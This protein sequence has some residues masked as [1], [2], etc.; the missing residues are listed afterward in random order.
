MRN[1]QIINRQWCSHF[2]L[3]SKKILQGQDSS[4]PSV[5]SPQSAGQLMQEKDIPYI[6]QYLLSLN[7]LSTHQPDS[8]KTTHHLKENRRLNIKPST[9]FYSFRESYG[10]TNGHPG[11]RP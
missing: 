11:L 1:R 3:N 4:L 9:A 8:P 10:F 7:L 5:T 2:Q 6:P